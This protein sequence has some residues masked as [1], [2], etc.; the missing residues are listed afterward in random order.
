M[1]PSFLDPRLKVVEPSTEVGRPIDLHDRTMT[2]D[3]YDSQ[4]I[5][6][7]RADRQSRTRTVMFA[8]TQTTL[9]PK[10]DRGAYPPLSGSM[11]G[12][13]GRL[14]GICRWHEHRG[15]RDRL[16]QAGDN[17]ASNNDP[18]PELVLHRARCGEDRKGQ[19][20]IGFCA[21]GGWTIGVLSSQVSWESHIVRPFGSVPI[22]V[23]SQAW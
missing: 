6:R 15:L 19:G 10:A 2:L 11:S 21:R 18:F 13:R 1:R 12:A 20:S 23:G 16:R 4:I 22:W 3:T 9:P 7:R 17:S 8:R 14:G 5:S